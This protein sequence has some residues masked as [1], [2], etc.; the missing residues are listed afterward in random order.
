MNP[1]EIIFTFSDDGNRVM[2]VHCF[3]VPRIGEEVLL[4]DQFKQQGKYNVCSVKWMFVE[5]LVIESDSYPILNTVE[6]HLDPVK[7]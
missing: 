4:Y 6:I 7:Q 1:I 5:Q 2:N 3:Y